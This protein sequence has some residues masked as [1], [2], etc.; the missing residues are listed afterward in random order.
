MSNRIDQEL[1]RVMAAMSDTSP[2]KPELGTPPAQRRHRMRR[3]IVFGLATGAFMAIS[4]V[5]VA[6]LNSTNPC[7][8][9]A[10][11]VP[12]LSCAQVAIPELID[13]MA[14]NGTDFEKQVVADGIVSRVELDQ[15]AQEFAKCATDA[16]ITG[17]EPYYDTRYKMYMFTRSVGDNPAAE[18]AAST[19]CEVSMLDT[20]ML[21]HLQEVIAKR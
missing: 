6:Q 13:K 21:W 10:G 15:A 5:A 1:I 9:P 11:D 18:E 17:F 14:T 16:G 12:G 2:D 4:V 3:R 8:P 7:Q 19:R 20:A